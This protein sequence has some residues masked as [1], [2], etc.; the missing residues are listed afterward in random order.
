MDV[1]L[2]HFSFAAL[3]RTPNTLARIQNA[4]LKIQSSAGEQQSINPEE[5]AAVV[6]TR[7][8]FRARFADLPGTEKL[9]DVKPLKEAKESEEASPSALEQAFSELSKITSQLSDL[10]DTSISHASGGDQAEKRQKEIATLKQRFN[11]IVSSGEFKSAL[12]KAQEL[13]K[14]VH[15]GQLNEIKLGD[16]TVADLIGDSALAIFAKGDFQGGQVFVQNLERV[17]AT[18]LGDEYIDPDALQ[19]LDDVVN[20]ISG[21]V[22][23]AGQGTEKSSGLKDIFDAVLGLA[24]KFK[25]SAYEQEENA[26]NEEQLKALALEFVGGAENLGNIVRSKD[27]AKLR[28]LLDTKNIFKS[29]AKD[30]VKLLKANYRDLVGDD[31]IKLFEGYNLGQIHELKR[32]L[33]TIASFELNSKKSEADY[34][35][36]IK[37]VKQSLFLIFSP[38]KKSEAQAAKEKA[39]KEAAK[40]LEEKR[41]QHLEFI[42]GLSEK[43]RLDLLLSPEQKEKALKAH[44][45]EP[46]NARFLLIAG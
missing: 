33:N 12:E 26:P 7:P 6:S 36:L 14:K 38:D 35:E 17:A 25:K 40:G 13:F 44:E 34:A 23:G 22:S 11:E 1:R 21:T 43:L 4:K 15:D 45:V 19:Q 37:Q 24:R 8:R 29:G 39:E 2:N 9:E 31:V 30:F 5:E 3:G 18:K 41:S 46:L 16:S 27:F 10:Y 32:T 28:D 42:T 20:N